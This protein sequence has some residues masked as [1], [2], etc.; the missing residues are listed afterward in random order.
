MTELFEP[1]GPHDHRIAVRA[2]AGPLG[3]LNEAGVL[4]SADVQ[5]ATRVG[6]L[7]VLADGRAV[8]DDLALLALALCVRSVRSGSVCLD[9]ATVATSTEVPEG[10]TWPAYDAWC[11]AIDASALVAGG[12]LHRD[13]SLVHLDRY[14]REERQVA[15]DLRAREELPAPAVDEALL[16]SGAAR[17][18]GATGDEEQRAAAR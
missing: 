11:A 13:G 1:D 6:A 5:V 2:P 7:A 18:F 12:V 15:A 3:L 16:A 4:T 14:L 10:W 8:E 17:V 9:L